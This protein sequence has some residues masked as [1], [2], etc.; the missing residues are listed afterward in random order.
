MTESERRQRIRIGRLA[1]RT[2][3]RMERQ[4]LDDPVERDAYRLINVQRNVVFLGQE[5][6]ASLDAIEAI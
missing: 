4:R 6:D 2:R 1:N 5:F 3:C